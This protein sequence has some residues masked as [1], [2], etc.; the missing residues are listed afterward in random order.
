MKTTLLPIS[1]PSAF[2]QA[3]ATLQSGG[4]VAFPTDTV[5]GL[6]VPVHSTT[7]INKLFEI[8]GRDSNK[9]IAVLIGSLEQLSILTPNFSA[10]AQKLATAFWPG[11]LTLVVAS[12]PSLPS[13][14]SPFPTIGI[15]MPNHNQ[16][17]KLLQLCGPLATTSANISG[18]TNTISAEEVLKQL[19]GKIDLLLD[20]GQTPGPIASTVVDCTQPSLTILRQGVISAEALQKIVA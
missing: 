5:Y 2:P 4:V 15:R 19:N 16:T 7:G 18:G 20:G 10:S 9:A 3:L 8:K 17:L 6:A 12:N 11:A 14:I 13:N 1:S